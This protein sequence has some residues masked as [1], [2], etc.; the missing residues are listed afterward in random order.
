MSL[1]NPPMVIAPP[2]EHVLLC[3]VSRKVPAKSADALCQHSKCDHIT[4]FPIHQCHW[5][6]VPAVA[7]YDTQGFSQPEQPAQ[8]SN[9]CHD[10]ADLKATT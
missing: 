2:L 1:L 5:N 9:L 3:K 6:P 4:A 7:Q 8:R 10:Y